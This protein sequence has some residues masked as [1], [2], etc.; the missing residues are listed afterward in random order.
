MI[1][2][3]AII[4]TPLNKYIFSHIVGLTLDSQSTIL[5]KRNVITS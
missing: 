2:L 5:K 3:I 1:G 4:V